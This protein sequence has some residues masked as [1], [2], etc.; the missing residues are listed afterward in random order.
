MMRYLTLLSFLFAPVQ[1]TAAGLGDVVCDDSARLEAQLTQNSGAQKQGWGMREPDT[2]IEVWI[3][4]GSGD[5]TMVQTHANGTSCIVAFGEH[6]H[7]L[8]TEA[9]PA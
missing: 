1:G 3:V 2:L 8:M 4:P 5:W 9:D 7:S 6:W